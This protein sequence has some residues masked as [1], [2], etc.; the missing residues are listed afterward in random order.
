MERLNERLAI[1]RR[2]LGTLEELSREPFSTYNEELAVQIYSRI[3][4]HLALMLD[5]VT[6]MESR[7]AAG[8]DKP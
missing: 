1:A 4:N 3:P 8:K 7:L 6:A 5:L 2:A